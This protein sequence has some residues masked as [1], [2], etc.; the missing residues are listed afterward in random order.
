MRHQPRHRPRTLALL[1]AGLALVAL[2]AAVGSATGPVAAPAQAHLDQEWG[3]PPVRV[4]E[5][6]APVV[7]ARAV[8]VVDYA[9]GALLFDKHAH[10]AL[11]PAS[12]T[13]ILTALVT[14]QT[15]DLKRRVIARFSPDELDP[16]STLMGVRPGEEVTI[17][18]LLYGLMLPS[19]NDAALVLARVVA[20]YEPAFVAMMNRA[21]AA[22]G[23]QRTL[24]INS[25][26]LDQPGHHTSAHDIAQLGRLAMRDP[27]FRAIVAAPSWTVR[28][29]RTYTVANRNPFLTAYRGADGVKIGFTDEAGQTIVASATRDGRRVIVAL[30]G[31]RD[32][33]GE[34]AAFMNWAFASY[35][36][37]DDPV[38][39]STASR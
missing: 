33:A 8:A 13:K 37:P 6:E 3:E 27:R 7:T 23:L 16:D 24:F 26:G 28:G 14:L 38:A 31:T 1:F 11:A 17:E 5:I 21:A 4:R 20:G 12:L 22:N 9:S 2:A 19:G 29:D 25:H 39:T 36:W 30:M 15:A 35:R 10:Q 32:R 18:D 34:S